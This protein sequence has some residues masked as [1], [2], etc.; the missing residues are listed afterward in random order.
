MVEGLG[1]LDQS[2][3]MPNFVCSTDGIGRL[4]VFR[5][6]REST[7]SACGQKIFK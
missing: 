7:E 5:G 3:N 6:V 2:N 1:I 4:T